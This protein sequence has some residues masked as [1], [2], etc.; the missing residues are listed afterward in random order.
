MSSIA[1][2]K[3]EL[4]NLYIQ[5]YAENGK[6]TFFK[7]KQ[8]IECA[9]IICT[10][11]SITDLI[12]NTIY[13]IDDSNKVF[14]DYTIFKLYMNPDIY[15]TFIYY[16]FMLFKK[17]LEIHKSY[18]V[19]IN[20]DGFTVTSAE[21]YKEIIKLYCDESA[22]NGTHFIDTLEFMKLY[23]LPSIVEMIRKILK[24]FINE[25]AYNKMIIMSKEDSKDYIDSIINKIDT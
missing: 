7:N 11:Y 17:I 19:H 8:K 14:I 25:N 12:A 13:Q 5:Y 24:P 18:E 3:A 2:C 20:L 21:R 10:K 22:K 15:T 9:K 6:N 23:N 4:N 1:N 16:I